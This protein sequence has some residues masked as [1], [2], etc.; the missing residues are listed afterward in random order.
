LRDFFAEHAISDVAC[1][2][3]RC[4]LKLQDGS[5]AEHSI[6]YNHSRIVLESSTDDELIFSEGA[7]T[8][9]TRTIESLLG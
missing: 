7:G 9:C 4:R 2:N 8:F 5:F 1:A 6:L 3:G